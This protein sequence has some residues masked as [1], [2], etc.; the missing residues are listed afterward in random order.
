MTKYLYALV[1][2]L[3]SANL[4]SAGY[5]VEFL[6]EDSPVFSARRIRLKEFRLSSACQK[7]EQ[8]TAKI[9]DEIGPLETFKI[10]ISDLNNYS[11]IDTKGLA[12]FINQSKEQRDA[13][14][15][16]Q[17]IVLSIEEDGKSDEDFIIYWA[18]TGGSLFVNGGSEHVALSAYQHPLPRKDKNGVLRSKIK[19]NFFNKSMS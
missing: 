3:L 17:S 15:D 11:Q 18:P 8:D 9:G 4:I 19:I 13:N 14:K 1:M 7:E 10:K 12:N 2:L 5:E 16:W 6:I